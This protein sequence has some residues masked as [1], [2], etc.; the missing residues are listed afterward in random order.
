MPWRSKLCHLW[1]IQSTGSHWHWTGS[2][3][4]RC[5]F[6]LSRLNN[7]AVGARCCW[8]DTPYGS[9]KVRIRT[10]QAVTMRATRNIDGYEIAH[11]KAIVRK[12]PLDGCET[13]PLR[14]VDLQKLEVFDN[15]CIRYILRC[16]LIDRVHIT[17]HRRLK[18]RPLPPVLFQRR[19]RQF[20][21][22]ARCPEGE[23]ICDTL[24]HYSLLKFGC[25]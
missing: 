9:C 12:I 22:A 13:W 18:L 20:G 10:F 3:W 14:A 25:I 7:N 23:L 21:R 5:S 8:G 11:P 15:D 24:F 17:L 6:C 19:L 1:L 4:K 16:H 2:I